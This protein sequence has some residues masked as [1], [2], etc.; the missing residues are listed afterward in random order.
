MNADK[1]RLLDVL[2]LAERAEL[3]DGEL[4]IGEIHNF[5]SDE[6]P[7]GANGFPNIAEATATQEFY[8]SVRGA[9][10]RFVAYPVQSSHDGCPVHTKTR[11]RHATVRIVLAGKTL[12]SSYCASDERTIAVART[13]HLLVVQGH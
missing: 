9:G 12:P 8:Q 6:G 7:A 11:C 13:S 3:A 1:I 5:E 4:V 10:D 2:D